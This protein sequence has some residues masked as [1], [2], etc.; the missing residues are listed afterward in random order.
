MMT[1]RTYS[2]LVRLETFEERYDYL[3]LGAQVG[4]STFG[5]ERYRNQR[6]Y[7][8]R[9]WKLIR[10][11]VIAR[12]LG[13]DLAIE[14]RDIYSKVIIHHMNPMT[15]ED[16]DKGNPDILNPEVLIT[17]TLLTHNA[18]H[19]GDKDQLKSD[20]VPRRPGDTQEW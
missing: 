18:I 12:D 13:C 16:V 8:S 2:E 14:G 17:T 6:F 11:E 10:D 19:Y 15:I 20:Y 5:F 1:F 3:R 9:Q 7:S 4:R